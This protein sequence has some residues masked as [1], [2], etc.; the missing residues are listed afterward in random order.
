MGMMSAP[1]MTISK[2]RIIKT[3]YWTDFDPFLKL[4]LYE[5]LNM[6]IT[7]LIMPAELQYISDKSKVQFT[8]NIILSLSYKDL[9]TIHDNER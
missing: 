3:F 2:C 8:F 1:A 7:L 4:F 9:L 6:W 5:T